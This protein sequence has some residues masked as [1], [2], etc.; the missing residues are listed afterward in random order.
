L[1]PAP[2]D[3]AAGAARRVGAVLVMCAALSCAKPP[4]SPSSVAATAATLTTEH[5]LLTYP[6]AQ[7]SAS[8]SAVAEALEREYA[9]ILSDL[10]AGS[11]PRVSVRF[12]ADHAALE[13]AV[14][15]VVGAIPSWASGLATAVDQIHVVSQIS[16]RDVVHEFAHCVSMRVNP[17]IPN[18]PRWLWEAVAIYEAGQAVDPRSVPSIAAAPPPFATLNRFDNTLIYEVGYTIAEFIVSTGGLRALVGLVAN[19]GDVRDT[20]GSSPEQFE[21]EWALFVRNRYGP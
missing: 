10:G 20:L 16:V 8:A 21:R 4:A 3:R 13:S 7:S 12:Y 15:P 18:N 17:T 1:P 6:A 2:A 14:A 11:M 19:N 9:R 5:F